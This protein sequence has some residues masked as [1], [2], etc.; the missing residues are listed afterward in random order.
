MPLPNRTLTAPPPALTTPPPALNRTSPPPAC[1][2]CFFSSSIFSVAFASTAPSHCSL[3]LLPLTAPSHCSLSL[4]PLTAPS[5]T[6]PSDLNIIATPSAQ[7]LRFYAAMVLFYI[8]VI[9]AGGNPPPGFSPLHAFTSP[10]RPLPR[11]SL[12][13]PQR[14][15]GGVLYLCDP[16]GRQSPP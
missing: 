15:H 13:P 8:Y 7:I 11:F 6:V 10:L 5:L 16:G 4:L 14:C 3:S 9:M 1:S 12:S 2:L